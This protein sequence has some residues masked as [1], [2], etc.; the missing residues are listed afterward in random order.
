M[1]RPATIRS[2][3]SLFEDACGVIE[4]E[5]ATDLQLDDL[6]R[7]VASSRRQLQRASAPRRGTA[8]IAPLP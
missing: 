3:T 2:R 6:A 4:E 8:N 5:Y 1:H 7:R